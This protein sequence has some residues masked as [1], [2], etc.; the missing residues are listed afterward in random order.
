MT[1]EIENSVYMYKNM[2][3]TMT[4]SSLLSESDVDSVTDLMDLIKLMIQTDSNRCY[5]ITSNLQ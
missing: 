2:L 3:K 5:D 4:T 1:N